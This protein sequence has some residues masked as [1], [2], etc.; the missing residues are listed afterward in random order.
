RRCH[1]RG[2]GERGRRHTCSRAEGG[3][4]SNALAG[5]GEADS[6]TTIRAR[7]NREAEGAGAD[8]RG[9]PPSVGPSARSTDAVFGGSSDACSGPLPRVSGAFY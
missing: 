7:C 3:S 2:E 9:F 1:C 8:R 4:R 5:V 6:G